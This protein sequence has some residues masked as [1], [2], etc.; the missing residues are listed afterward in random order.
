MNASKPS[1]AAERIDLK[2]PFPLKLHQLLE[3]VEKNGQSHIISWLP[4]GK[5]FR[6]HH[7]LQFC[8]TVMKGYFNQTKFK[9]FTRQVSSEPSALWKSMP[10][11]LLTNHCAASCTS[12][13]SRKSLE[14]K[15]KE[16]S[17]M[18]SLLGKI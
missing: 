17:F 18:T 4:G 6:V 5:S 10:I 1:A 12:T 2:L 13:V 7:P 15:I 16:H 8:E 3:D 14:A 9:S 11:S